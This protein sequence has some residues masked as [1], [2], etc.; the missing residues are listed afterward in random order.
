MAETELS[1]EKFE[2]LAADSER[3]SALTIEMEK[4][5][6]WY[7]GHPQYPLDFEKI[8]KKI[9]EAHGILANIT[10]L[11]DD[12]KNAQAANVKNEKK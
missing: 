12:I 4:V 7:R 11:I 10:V 9:L 8:R 3:I 2:R 6:A 1:Q 5:I